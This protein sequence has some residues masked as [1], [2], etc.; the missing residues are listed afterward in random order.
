QDVWER[1]PPNEP[2]SWRFG[3]R[4]CVVAELEPEHQASKTGKLGSSPFWRNTVMTSCSLWMFGVIPTLKDLRTGLSWTLQETPPVVETLATE[5]RRLEHSG[6]VWY[7]KVLFTRQL[8]TA[9][10]AHISMF[11]TSA[12]QQGSTYSGHLEV[13]FGKITR[14]H[15]LSRSYP[16]LSGLLLASSSFE[17]TVSITN[18]RSSKGPCTPS[19]VPILD[20]KRV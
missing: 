10:P 12:L 1:S 20:I 13:W 11:T 19:S 14:L 8:C 4:T 16:E 2:H 18:G 3:K 6:A 9:S 7:Y 5:R 17:H 15:R